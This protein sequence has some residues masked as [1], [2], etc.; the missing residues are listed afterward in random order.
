MSHP[1]NTCSI[2][3]PE[4]PTHLHSHSGKQLFP[5]AVKSTS[6]SRSAAINSNRFAT[7]ISGAEQ[8]KEANKA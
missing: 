4:S 5:P 1:N 6:Q 7:D 3:T 2:F 8:E